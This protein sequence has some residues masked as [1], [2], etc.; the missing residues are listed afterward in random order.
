VEFRFTEEKNWGKRAYSGFGTAL[1]GLFLI[2]FQV[3]LNGGS[4]DSL[5]VFIGFM[6]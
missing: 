2:I 6:K 1:A 3:Y 4:M 5:L